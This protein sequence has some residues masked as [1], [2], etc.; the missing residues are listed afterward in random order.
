MKRASSVDEYINLHPQWHSP[1]TA[2]RALLLSTELQE[3]IKWGMPTYCLKNKNVIGLSA[4]KEYCGLWF[5][6][7]VFLDDPDARLHNAQDGKTKGMRQLRFH[8]QD[9]VTAAY[10][11]AFVAQA[12][13]NEKQGKRIQTQRSNQV[14]IPLLLQQALENDRQLQQSFAKLTPGKQKEYAQHIADAKRD[15]TKQSR[16]DKIMPMIREGIGLNDKYRC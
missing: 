7:G 8:P 3:T 14:D 1:L 12:I 13:N 10:I 4:F 5:H 16:L 11:G 9:D 6:Q 2:L 15:A